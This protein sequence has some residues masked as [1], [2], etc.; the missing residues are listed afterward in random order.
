MLGL[1]YIESGNKLTEKIVGTY[2]HKNCEILKFLFNIVLK[3]N[4]NSVGHLL[5]H[6]KVLPKYKYTISFPSKV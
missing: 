2:L 6:S 1:E 3:G 4:I 5:T